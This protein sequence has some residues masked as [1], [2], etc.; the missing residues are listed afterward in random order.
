ME[1]TSLNGWPSLEAGSL[2][3]SRTIKMIASFPASVKKNLKN[4]A[5]PSAKGES[6]EAIAMR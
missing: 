2:A 1:K 5:Q 3:I 4:A 6:D